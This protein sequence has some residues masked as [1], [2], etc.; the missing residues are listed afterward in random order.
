MVDN[1]EEVWEMARNGYH[2]GDENT[3]RILVTGTPVGLGSEKVITPGRGVWR[4][5]SG[6]AKLQWLPAELY[7]DEWTPWT[8][9]CSWQKNILGYPV[10]SSLIR[11]TE[12][13]GTDDLKFQVDGLLI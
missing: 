13:V 10:R 12:N 11:K 6:Y 8:R 7:I 4:V 3:P 9:S 2:V 1:L 5:G